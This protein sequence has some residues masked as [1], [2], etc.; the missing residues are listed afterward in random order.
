M[1]VKHR[2]LMCGD[3]DW[4]DEFIVSLI[5]DSGRW[6][7]I[8]GAARGADS[9]AHSQARSHKHSTKRFA[10]KWGEHGKA[11][12]PVRNQQMIDEGRPS[13][14]IAFHDDIQNSKGTKDMVERAKKRN[15]PV[16]VVSHG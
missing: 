4:Q 12:G 9:I 14:V 2:V 5:L 15:I 6:M 1:S 11:A 13:V 16:Y 7:V 8:D 10:A 3:R